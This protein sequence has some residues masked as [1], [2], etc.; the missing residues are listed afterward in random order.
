MEMWLYH[1]FK[2]IPNMNQ[3]KWTFL[4]KLLNQTFTNENKYD[5]LTAHITALLEPCR[6]QHTFFGLNGILQYKE[7]EMPKY[8][9]LDLLTSQ[10]RA[11]TTYA[12]P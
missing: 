2:N 10:S 7:V 11:D 8:Q 12:F 1:L 9:T 6:V 4:H 3:K 5:K